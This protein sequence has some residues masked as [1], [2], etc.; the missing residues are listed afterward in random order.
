MKALLASHFMHR[1]VMGEVEAGSLQSA[2]SKESRA[3]FDVKP[4]S[5]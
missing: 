3:K 1:V 4:E 2:R 5:T